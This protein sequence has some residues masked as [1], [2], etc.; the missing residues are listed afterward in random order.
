MLGS[1][2]AL[3]HGTY[4]C[5]RENVAVSLLAYMQCKYSQE[6]ICSF[7]AGQY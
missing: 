4:Y 2:L 5:G 3:V 7:D 1:T 6:P